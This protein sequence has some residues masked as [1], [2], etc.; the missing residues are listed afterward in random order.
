[1][2]QYYNE[3]LNALPSSIDFN[4]IPTLN[5]S[6]K[7][8]T[9]TNTSDVSILFAIDTTNAYTFTPSNGLIPKQKSITIQIKAFPTEAKVIVTNAKV[10]LDSKVSKIIKISSISK[11]PYLS[12]NK[13]SLEFGVIQIG[14]SSIQELIISNPENVAATFTITKHS[15]QPGK[16]PDIFILS[17]TN[18]EVPPHSSF[19][20]KIKYQSCFP[21]V[22]AYETFDINTKGGNKLRFACSGSCYPLSVWLSSKCVNFKAIPLGNQMTK[23]I[24]LYNGSDSVTYFQIYHN[25]DGV[26]RFDKLQGEV[27]PRANTRINVTFRPYETMTYY[28]RIFCLVQHHIIISIDLYG[29]CNDLLT[30][31]LVIEQKYIDIFRYKILNGLYFNNDVA[32][33]SYVECENEIMK[34]TTKN[35]VMCDHPSQLQL[36]KE[37]FWETTATTRIVSFDTE[38]IDFRFVECFKSSEGYTVRVRNNTNAKVEVKWILEKPINISNLI[39]S[40]NLFNCNECVFIVQPEQCFINKHS[41][42]EFKVYFKPNQAEFYFY[43]DIT[44]QYRI[45]T[46]GSADTTNTTKDEQNLRYAS[47]N[48]HHD[49]FSKRKLKPLTDKLSS[50]SS[51]AIKTGISSQLL[52]NKQPQNEYFDPPMSSKLSVVGHSFPPG[53]QIFIPIYEIDPSHELF[54]PPSTLQQSV[55]QTLRITNKSD[56][57][58]FYNITPDTNNVFRVQRKHGLIPGGSFHLICIEF[59]PKDNVVYRHP[60]K[61]TLNHDITN[62]KTIMLNA[63]SV[64]P[65]IELEGIKDEIYFPPSYVGIT[66]TKKVTVINRSPIKVNVMIKTEQN[67]PHGVLDIRPNS[68]E[69]GTN[70]VKDVEIAFTPTKQRQFIS[71]LEFNVNRVY[72]STVEC[73]GVFNPGS[74]LSG[75]VNKQNMNTSNTFI[76]EVTVL[77]SGSDGEIAI[78][79]MNIDFGTVKVGFHKKMSFVIS[80]PTNTNFYIKIVVEPVIDD[81]KQKDSITFDFME[82]LINALCKRE[83]HVTFEPLTRSSIVLTVKLYAIESASTQLQCEDTKSKDNNNN[84]NEDV[85]VNALPPN[86]SL[87][88]ELVIK[89]NGDY[90]LMKIVDIRNALVGTCALWYSFNVD[91]ANEELSK[92]LTDEE[93]NYMSNEKDNTKKIHEITNQLRT[94]KFDFGKHVIKKNFNHDPFDVYLTLKNEGGVPC[95]FFFKFSDDIAIKRE[96]WMDPVEPSSNDKLEYHVLKEKIFQIEPRKNKLDPNECCNIRLRY[97]RKEIGEHRLRVIFQIVNGKPLIF[98]L[99]GQCYNEKQGILEIK[100]P[101]LDFSYVPIGYMDYLVSPLELSNAGGVKIRYKIEQGQIDKFNDDNNNFEVFKVNSTEGSIGPGDLQ[102]LPVFF[103]PLTSKEYVMNLLVHY[104]DEINGVKAIPITIKGKGYHP[105]EFEP[106][107]QKSP[108]ITMPQD[109]MCNEYEG[110]FIQKCG[111]SVEEID[112]GVMEESSVSKTFILYNFSNTNSFGFDIREPGFILKDSMIIKPNKGKLEPNS[113]ILIKITL[114]PKGY[115]SNYSGEIEINVT[116]SAENSNKVLEKEKLHIRIHKQNKIKESC[117]E[118]WRSENEEQSFIETMLCDFT[119]EILSEQ[120]F[121]DLFMKNIDNQP[122][123]LFRWTSNVRY[124]PQEEVRRLLCERYRKEAIRMITAENATTF[125]R[126]DRRGSTVL[127]QQQQELSKEDDVQ[128]KEVDVFGEEEDLK[129]QEKYMTELLD[130]YKM[131]VN[132]V[133]EALAVVNEESRKLISNDIMEATI[134]NIISEAVYGEADLT[135]KTR[136]YFFNK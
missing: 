93:I 121:V 97:N 19:L 129:I 25:N 22:P 83:V 42:A 56:T 68:F 48:K 30:K 6:T 110:T 111:V 75:K 128:E 135:E 52:I 116:W 125:K 50:L 98:E 31:S 17:H 78:S 57:P 20:L 74:S 1:M 115:F 100:R 2:E 58:L 94:V 21:D 14:K 81:K 64:N 4:F 18:G 102:Y 23:L 8:I 131:S 92:Q 32:T 3:I 24:R 60:L 38:F 51:F 55:Y 63:L 72:D 114:T 134:Y 65:V 133:N 69:M 126:T 26:F 112:F 118:L 16:H 124:P 127:Q 117:G 54:F 107:K 73:I 28:E 45:V 34:S 39:R 49:A 120:S 86:S 41:V 53:N 79:P 71:K 47:T 80:N 5:E 10:T 130:K 91:E 59:N 13:A 90:P 101:M 99:F 77:G 88:C 122:N 89:A 132:E 29:A 36:H 12:L 9:L 44:C 43:A 108:F 35:D 37:M 96:I 15:E 70:L 66:T 40:T 11:F 104:T 109:R 106:P 87:K 136:I 62:T 7:T 61:I 67:H 84:N 82:G 119:K 46:N 85:S 76:R 123:T 113:H 105:L 33:K 27:S 95:E 103:R